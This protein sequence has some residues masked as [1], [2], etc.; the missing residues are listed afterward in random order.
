[1]SWISLEM[2]ETLADRFIN[3]G[4]FTRLDVHGEIRL[5]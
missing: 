5:Y 2:A 1:M 3:I 4:E